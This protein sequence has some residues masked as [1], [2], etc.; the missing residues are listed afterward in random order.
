MD[1]PVLSQ[2]LEALKRIGKSTDAAGTNTLFA[3]VAQGVASAQKVHSIPPSATNYTVL[4]V[5]GSG[6]LNVVKIHAGGTSPTITIKVTIDGVVSFTS[7]IALP[8]N[9]DWFYDGFGNPLQSNPLYP[10]CNL[11]FKNSLLVELNAGTNY[12][13]CYLDLQY[14]AA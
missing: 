10:Y 14:E 12:S 13:G 3:R 9:T 8:A 11:A 1:V 7:N 4:S 6:R 2:V 5:T